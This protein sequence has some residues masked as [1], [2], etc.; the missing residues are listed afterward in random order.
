MLLERP[1]AYILMGNGDN[2]PVH[3][4]EYNFNDDAIPAGVSFWVELAKSQI[5]AI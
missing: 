2:A 3:H 4:P 5:L 1:G